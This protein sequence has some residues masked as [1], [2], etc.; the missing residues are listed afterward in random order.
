MKDKIRAETSIKVSESA[1]CKLK[2]SCRSFHNLY[3]YTKSKFQYNQWL[4]YNTQLVCFYN[5]FYQFG[6]HLSCAH[7]SQSPLCS[8]SLEIKSR[9]LFMHNF[10]RE[11]P[12]RAHTGQI[13]G[14]FKLGAFS[15]CEGA[16]CTISQHLREGV[17]AARACA[18][19][20]PPAPS[21]A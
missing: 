6:F 15:C 13:S 8:F 14:G 21:S 12:P 19:C 9:L 16:F 4:L 11:G 20:V 3:F 18:L 10:S 2:N 5:F 7:Q 1:L 17:S